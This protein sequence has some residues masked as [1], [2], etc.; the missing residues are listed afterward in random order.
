V[1]SG[2]DLALALVERVL[3]A[4]VRELTAEIVEQETPTVVP[5]T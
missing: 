2:I 1:S 3:G 4:A 5:A